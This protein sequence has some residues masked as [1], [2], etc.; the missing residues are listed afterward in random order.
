MKEL[1]LKMQELKNPTILTHHEIK[2]ILGGSGEVSGSG[3]VTCTW[4]WMP[5]WQT[6]SSSTTPCEGN[7]NGCQTAADAFCWAHDECVNVDCQ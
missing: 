2:N 7:L 6:K 4:T 3:A 1:R 5:G